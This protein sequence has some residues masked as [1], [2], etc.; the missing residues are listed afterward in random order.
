MNTIHINE[1]YFLKYGIKFEK[2]RQIFLHY[3]ASVNE[4]KPDEYRKRCFWTL[5]DD[6]RYGKR[7]PHFLIQEV[8][9]L[10]QTCLDN[11]LNYSQSGSMTP[12]MVIQKK[13][14][15]LWIFTHICGREFTQNLVDKFLEISGIDMLAEENKEVWGNPVYQKIWLKEL[16]KNKVANFDEPEPMEV[17]EPIQYEGIPYIE[18]DA[19]IGYLEEI[20]W[21]NY[22][23]EEYEVCSI[24]NQLDE[25]EEE[26]MAATQK[27]YTPHRDALII[28]TLDPSKKIELMY[29]QAEEDKGAPTPKFNLEWIDPGVEI[30]YQPQDYD[31][32]EAPLTKLQESISVELT[33]GYKFNSKDNLYLIDGV[34]WQKHPEKGWICVDKRLTESA[35]FSIRD[36]RYTDHPD[37][38]HLTDL[39]DM[40]Q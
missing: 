29:Y 17:E 11:P 7:E 32:M 1:N 13:T 37:Y 6:T 35:M 36:F 2:S 5:I 24:E 39:V 15:I 40:V 28:T 19:P 14:Q 21:V 26:E 18:M 25:I 23:D 34:T 12:R 4:D 33:P 27:M 16:V 20:N 22:N 38:H 9:W 30:V 10:L 3:M 8:F 31:L